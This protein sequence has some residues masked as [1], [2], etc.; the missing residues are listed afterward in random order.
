[1]GK[2]GYV[3]GVCSCK[4]CSCIKSLIR[5][6]ISLT[7][8]DVIHE[9]ST[10]YFTLPLLCIFCIMCI[11]SSGP[12]GV[13]YLPVQVCIDPPPKFVSDDGLYDLGDAEEGA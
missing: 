10:M 8:N 11:L 12:L 9:F 2:G 1:M 7:Y 5:N 3:K 13:G 6:L 4:L